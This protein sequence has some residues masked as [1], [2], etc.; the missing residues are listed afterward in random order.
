M[1]KNTRL[2]FISIILLLSINVLF[3]KGD[4]E[5]LS[6]TPHQQSELPFILILENGDILAI[7]SEGY[8]FNAE[9][10]F[11]YSLRSKETGTWSAPTVAI[12]PYSNCTFAQ[13]ALDDEGTV[14]IVYT[15]G[16]GGNREVYYA[17]YD[18]SKNKWSGRKKVYENA[19]QNDSWPRIKIQGNKIYIMWAYNYHPEVGDMDIVMVENEIGGLWPIERHS[20]QTVSDLSAS[21]SVHCDF[22]V[23][24]NGNI[25]AAWMDDNHMQGNWNIYYNSR[26]NGVWGKAFHLYPDWNEY[27][28]ALIV[29]DAGLVHIIYCNKQ[30]PV[31]Y[32][33]KSGSWGIPSAGWSDRKS[34]SKGATDHFTFLFMRYINGLLHAIIKQGGGVFYVR[35]LPDG[36]WADPVKVAAG[37]FPEYS[38]MDV[39]PEG[40]VHVVWSD[41]P[42]PDDAFHRDVYY[43][44]VELPGK[45]PEAVIEA[46][47]AFGLLPLEVDF[48]A[49]Q[50]SDKDGKI[51]GYRWNF[52]DGETA[53][54]KKVSHTFADEGTYTVILTVIDDDLL[55]GTAKVDIEVSSGQPV[56]SFEASS[57]SGLVPLKVE[58]NASA[59]IDPDGDIVT[60]EWD[61]GDETTGE[62]QV[63]THRYTFGGAFTVSLTVTDNDGK[64]DTATKELRVYEKP[65]ALFSATPTDGVAPLDVSLDASES[66][67]TDG[68]IVFYNWDFGDGST[69]VGDK[70]KRSH[71]YE[72][73]G[74]YQVI[75]TVVDSD[76]YSETATQW[77]TVYDKP[78]SPLDV[79]I[80]R[81]VNRTLFFRDYIN[82]ITWEGN[83]QNDPYFSVVQYKIYRKE[84]GQ[85]DEQF[86]LLAEVGSVTLQYEDRKFESLE[87]ADKYA[88][89]V[90]AVDDQGRESLLSK[91]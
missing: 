23:D 42:D 86:S 79:S 33:Q 3:L 34:I 37:T 8:H 78:F 56:A 83:P 70:V 48:D 15:D 1:K 61:F 90:S 81:L 63:V 77:I 76:Y 53:V 40:N 4:V 71:T 65:H 73:G 91:Y 88:Y 26:I 9:A 22:D 6:N 27:A 52:G 49:S 47:P 59:S 80:E 11:Y 67:D 31:W 29:D 50:S 13:C 30:N 69:H 75:L 18:P 60:Y 16:G 21:T 55:S 66:Y 87:E 36:R 17:T 74:T 57:E 28:P 89:A 35:G 54:G 14:H 84:K 43:T 19:G 51:I 5:N 44:Q 68:E 41:G 58:F 12:K 62:G 7:W 25:Y 72:A 24:E 85:G 32:Q 82:R 38:G 10:A 20:R 45:P 64:T 46:S 2:I 39:D